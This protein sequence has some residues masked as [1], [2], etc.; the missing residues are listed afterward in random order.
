MAEVAE[1]GFGKSSLQH[2]PGPFSHLGPQPK[3]RQ[4]WLKLD[5]QEM[6]SDRTAGLIIRQLTFMSTCIMSVDVLSPLLV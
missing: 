4:S 6:F 1:R 2:L 3:L 5:A